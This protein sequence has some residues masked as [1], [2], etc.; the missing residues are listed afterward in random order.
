MAMLSIS[1]SGSGPA[2]AS[3]NHCTVQVQGY[4]RTRNGR[5]EDV[6][7]YER[8]NP[9]CNDND[10]GVASP[11][12]ARRPDGF[13]DGRG[14]P[15]PL[16]PPI[17]VAPQRGGGSG[18]SAGRPGQPPPTVPRPP[19]PPSITP[20]HSLTE[21]LA[22]GGQPI[23]VVWQGAGPE[24]RTFSGGQAAGRTLFEDMISGRGAMEATPTGYPGQMVRLPDGSL[25]GFRPGGGGSMPA[26]DIEIPG[27]GLI[28]KLHFR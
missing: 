7:G 23:G 18:A 17:G 4:T 21:F 6:S 10:N 5:E 22:P 8:S 27:F 14:K 1:H 9:Y 11:V 24:V 25:I 2:S 28:Q 19:M 26:I 12:M 3:G 13:E 16:G 15:S 20:S